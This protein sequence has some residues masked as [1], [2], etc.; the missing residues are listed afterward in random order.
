MYT[1][2]FPT[3]ENLLEHFAD[4]FDDTA[5]AVTSLVNEDGVDQKTIAYFEDAPD[6]ADVT[7]RVALLSQTAGIPTPEISIEEVPQTDWLEHVY[8]GLHPL[9]LGRFYIYGSHEK[10]IHPGDR[11]PLLI[12]AATAFGSGHHST[13]A[14][15]LMMLSEYAEKNSPEKMLDLGCGAGTLAMGMAKLFNRKVIAT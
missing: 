5:L 12:D 14:A 13:T 2:S 9:E 8:R 10:E 3:P 4:A 11:I 1:L 6:R 7:A 15:C